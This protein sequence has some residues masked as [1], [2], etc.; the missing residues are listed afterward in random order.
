MKLNISKIF[1][2]VHL[3]EYMPELKGKVLLVWV[4]PTR[5]VLNEKDRLVPDYLAEMEAISSERKALRLAEVE[6]Q[7]AFEKQ[8][9]ETPESPA[10]DAP[11]EDEAAAAT[12]AALDERADAALRAFNRAVMCW[13]A[14]IWSQADDPETHWTVEE[15]EELER[16]DPS[17]FQFMLFRSDGL[18]AAHRKQAKKA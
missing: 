13:W 12:K 7:M 3:D 14:G 18:L 10:A 11:L 9:A 2:Q 8:A 4:N 17:F 1:G 15:L 5:S 6:R 16:D